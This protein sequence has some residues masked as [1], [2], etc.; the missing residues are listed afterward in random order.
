MAWVLPETLSVSI[1]HMVKNTPGLSRRVAL[2]DLSRAYEE[3]P[4]CARL[5]ETDSVVLEEFERFLDGEYG[6]KLAPLT[7]KGGSERRSALSALQV[8]A[9]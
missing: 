1:C 4:T 5:N 9:L 3:N 7:L 6:I 2:Y 8:E